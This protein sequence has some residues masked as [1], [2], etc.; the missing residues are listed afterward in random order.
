MNLPASLNR[1][2][3]PA[4]GVVFMLTLAAP[5]RGQGSSSVRTLRTQIRDEH[6]NNAGLK[7]DSDDSNLELLTRIWES[8]GDDMDPRHQASLNCSRNANRLVSIGPR[9]VPHLISILNKKGNP[10]PRRWA[11]LV[12][13]GIGADEDHREAAKEAIG[14]LTTIL[15]TDEDADAR[16]NA[17]MALRYMNADTPAAIDAAIEALNCPNTKVCAAAA[18]CLGEMGPKAKRAIQPLIGLLDRTNNPEVRDQTVQTLGKF[19]AD[20]TAAIEPLRRIFKDFREGNQLSQPLLNVIEALGRMGPEAQRSMLELVEV[21]G[22]RDDSN[23]PVA[24][25]GTT[26]SQ[27]RSAAKI[28]INSICDAIIDSR[29]VG[30]KLILRQAAATLKEDQSPESEEALNS[31]NRALHHLDMLWGANL[32]TFAGEHIFLCWVTTAYASLFLIIASLFWIEPL[33][34]FSAN[35]VLLAV[36]DISLPKPFN[37]I[38]LPVR[39]IL[40]MGFFHYH[41]RVLDA[42]VNNHISKARDRFTQIPTVSDRESYVPVSIVLD[43][44]ALLTARSMDLRPVFVGNLSHL[45]IL[46]QGGC[47][48]TSLA[49]QLGRWSMDKE[50]SQRLCPSHLMLPILIEQ[51]LDVHKADTQDLLVAKVQNQ[52]RALIDAIHPPSVA[53]VRQLLAQRRLLVIIDSLSEMDSGSSARVI[54]AVAEIPMNATIITSR[55][56]EHLADL[57]FKHV[58]FPQ[59]IKGSSLFTFIESYLELKKKRE[60]FD[61]SELYAACSKFSL[62]GKRNITALLA[63]LYTDQ[64]IAAKEDVQDGTLN[65]KLPETIPDLMLC[66]IKILNRRAPPDAPL[67]RTVIVASKALAWECVKK[68]LRPMPSS[69][70]RAL[71]ALRRK[72]VV[73]EMRDVGVP[74]CSDEITRASLIAYLDRNLNLIRS[75]DDGLDQIRFVL[76]PLSEYLASLCLIGKYRGSEKAWRRFLKRARTHE[77]YRTDISGFLFALQDCCEVKASEFNIPGFVSTELA[78]IAKIRI[79]DPKCAE[80][81]D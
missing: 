28:S 63:K 48:K 79:E 62:I 26:R 38:R 25:D 1:I 20:A 2:A 43:K 37:A 47:G 13:G 40:L 75:S 76:D 68:T 22:D 35:E 60:L 3:V 77:S 6:R 67:T 70:Q 16:R 4:A 5:I 56:D 23:K 10:S 11:A 29:S 61:Y 44:N 54:N 52:L 57:P 19:G 21:L 15:I 36:T 17:A 27:I 34:L 71:R 59:N 64:L 50:P 42:W 8:C 14:P 24:G 31:V 9:A 80:Q 66:S 58:T 74:S 33:W 72:E 45:V 69:Y 53:L 78:D 12:L 49:C 41:P 51:D 39:H 30:A 7:I 46:G 81:L 65:S 55:V 73:H 32:S 18:G